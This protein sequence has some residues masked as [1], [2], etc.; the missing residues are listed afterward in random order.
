M[1]DCTCG[2]VRHEPDC[3]VEDRLVALTAHV[4][5]TAETAERCTPCLHALTGV[6]PLGRCER[7]TGVCLTTGGPA[8][9]EHP[10]VTFPPGQPA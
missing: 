6:C 10:G 5:Q 9:T 7:V 2:V 8:A 3:P 4:G 1:A